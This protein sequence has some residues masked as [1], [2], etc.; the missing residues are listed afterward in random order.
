MRRRLITFLL[1]LV[2]IGASI[3]AV[4]FV[5]DYLSDPPTASCNA[6]PAGFGQATTVLTRQEVL[7]HYTC[8]GAVQAGTLYLPSKP[9]PHPA[10]I[11]IHG[12]GPERRLGYAGAL[13][14]LVDAGVAVYSYDKRGVGESQGSCCPGDNGHFNLLSADI[15][16]A[17]AAL[18][19]IPDGFDPLPYWRQLSVRSLWM[20]GTE[21]D[22]IPV[23][24]TTAL[25]NQLK[26][27]GKSIEIVTFAG[28]GHGLLDVPPSAADAP[29]TLVGWVVQ[30]VHV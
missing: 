8:E 11:W 24:E 6:P 14:S 16:G 4:L 23:P 10:V 20:L 30:R 18:A 3:A 19:S 27:E 26:N 12:A 15:A 22:R 7:V 28:A 13:A 25:L 17:V 29:R 1:A 2:G 5:L 9:G 21:D